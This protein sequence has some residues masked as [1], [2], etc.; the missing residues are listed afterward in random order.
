MTV[1]LD[2]R[3]HR[4]TYSTWRYDPY[5]YC[6]ELP[7]EQFYFFLV[8]HNGVGD[9]MAESR[10]GKEN[11]RLMDSYTR[12][13]ER[14]THYITAEQLQDVLTSRQL[15]VRQKTLNITGPQLA[16]LLARPSRDEIL[17]E[18][19]LLQKEVGD[20][21]RQVVAILEGKCDCCEGRLYGKQFI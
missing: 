13:C 10:G 7:L 2:R 6:L 19:N 12:L 18:Q 16:D 8:R 3:R 9:V 21:G 1:C 20:F 17:A 4:E 14:G 11:Q 15:K 5:H